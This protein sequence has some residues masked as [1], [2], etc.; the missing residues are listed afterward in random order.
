VE[1]V[2]F[3]KEGSAVI[4]MDDCQVPAIGPGENHADLSKQSRNQRTCSIRLK[5]SD[6]DDTQA[7]GNFNKE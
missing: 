3:D 2:D 4:P 7:S 5:R 1:F 6:L